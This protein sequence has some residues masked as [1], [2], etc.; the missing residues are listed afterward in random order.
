[1]APEHGW[2]PVAV[3]VQ[4]LNVVMCRNLRREA[5]RRRHESLVCSLLLEGDPVKETIRFTLNGAPVTL[6]TETNRKLLWVL[7]TDLEQTGTGRR[8]ACEIMHRQR[9]L[10]AG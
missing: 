1:M 4:L 3:S 7:R 8:R 10:C 2:R 9:R 6:D 5:D